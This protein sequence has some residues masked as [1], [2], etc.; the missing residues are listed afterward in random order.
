MFNDV[1]LEIKEESNSDK[2]WIAN[3]DEGDSAH[4]RDIS[5][6]SDGESICS[7]K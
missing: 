3:G 2:E 4:D 5:D 1:A 6:F 7:G